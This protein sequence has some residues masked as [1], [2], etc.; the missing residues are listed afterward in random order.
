MRFVNSASVFT[1][2]VLIVISQA[3]TPPLS[4]NILPKTPMSHTMGKPAHLEDTMFRFFG[5]S[6]LQDCAF[7]QYLHRMDVI[8]DDM[9]DDILRNPQAIEYTVGKKP[10]HTLGRLWLWMLRK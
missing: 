7:L 3:Y 1:F 5:V 8:D 2:L 10:N 6:L 4:P 9:Y